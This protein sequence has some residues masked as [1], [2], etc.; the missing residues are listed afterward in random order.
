LRPETP[1]LTGKLTPL[2]AY[3]LP[4]TVISP[5][6]IWIGLDGSVWPWDQAWYGRGSVELFSLLLHSPANWTFRML[7][8]LPSQ[9]P[10]VT[11]LG[12]F[13]VPL[14]YLLG[15]VDVGL[16]LSIFVTQTLSLLLMCQSVRELSDH[17]E[18]VTITACLAMASAPLFVGLSHQYLAE[19]LQLL[20]VTWFVLIMT[21]APKWN[22]ALILSQLLAAT[23][24]AMLA[25]V[26]SPLY[27]VGP[28]LVA[29]W[30][31]WRPG[32]CSPVKHHRL[33]KPLIA[34]FVAGVLLTIAAIGWYYRNLA[35]A[36]E[37]VSR[38]SSG[39][40][41][42]IYG[43]ADT[44]PNAML[45]WLGAL[46]SS[47]FLP[48]VFSLASVVI[49]FA[50]I[51]R[52]VK[53]GTAGQHFTLASSVAA[54]Q[55]LVV[56]VLFSFSSNREVRYLLPLLPYLA[57]LIC[58]SLRELNGSILTALIIFFFSMQLATTYGQALGIVRLDPTAR[59]LVPPNSLSGQKEA[60]ILRSI[61]SRTCVKAG[62]QPYWSIV[63]IEL[64]WLNHASATYFA[65]KGL[66]LDNSVGCNYGSARSVSESPERVWAWISSPHIRYYVALAPGLHPALDDAQGQA[67]NANYLPMLAKVR[68]SG[69]FELEP[70]LA[71]DPSV[72]IFR[73]RRE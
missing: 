52:L 60:K 63:G 51:L 55:T 13:F 33:D 12:Q 47:F 16:L 14:G 50:V 70:S 8:V 59:W 68:A 44:F 65:A 61:I 58:W 9:A 1:T 4:V 45:Y 18:L 6:L 57:L 49:G 28:G 3:L 46:R 48:S 40:I 72:L 7:D 66:M 32:L 20:A 26:S 73:R 71:E 5:S 15:S 25:K 39:P 64:P 35:H 17:S 29:L 2:L 62:P 30:Y 43:K 67:I 24:V 11:W 56:L 22:R 34:V 69:L 27:C 53:P 54:L 37:H 31:V 23:P 21:F 38:S 41:A 19:P 42:E 36:I 10:G